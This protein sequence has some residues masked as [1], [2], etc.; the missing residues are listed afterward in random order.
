MSW[1]H[2]EDAAAATVAALERASA[3]QAYNIVDD[4]P[5]AWADKATAT[6]AQ[7]AK[8]RRLPGWLMGLVPYLGRLMMHTTMRVAHEKA[9]RELGWTPKHPL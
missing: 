5:M 1:I 6:A 4:C 3:G 7:G 8:A 2:V 9:T